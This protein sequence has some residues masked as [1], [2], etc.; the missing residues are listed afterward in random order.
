MPR[1]QRDNRPIAPTP[2]PPA[3]KRQRVHALDWLRVLAFGL[4]IFFHSAVLFIPDAIPDMPN[5]E[6]S[7][8]LRLFV[9]FLHQFRLDL[10]FLVSGVGVCFA[11][12]ARSPRAFLAERSR[13]LL[14]PLVFGILVVV[15]PMVFLEKSYNNALEDGPGGFVAFYGSMFD[16]RVYPDGSLSWHHYWFIDYLYLFCLLALPLFLH[17]RGGVGAGRFERWADWAAQGYRL[18]ALCLPLLAIELALRPLFPGFRNLLGDWASFSHWLTIFIAGWAMAHR[19]ILLDRARTLRRSSLIVAGC[20]NILLFAL[21]Y[22]AKEG[23]SHP[24]ELTLANALSFALFSSL[25]VLSAW[26]WLLC[27]L[28]FALQWLNRP[29]KALGY[30]NRAVYPLFCLHQT[31]IVALGYCILPL[32]WSIGAKFWAISLG[33]FAIVLTLYEIAI[34]RSAVLGAVL[35][36]AREPKKARAVASFPKQRDSERASRR[37]PAT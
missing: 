6:S 7:P 31:T 13:R 18:F 11:L 26:A 10:L 24:Q 9:A 17:W 30:L 34:R 5:A 25:R 4:L 3:G 27:C 22:S 12:G 15:P 29:G 8:A 37:T 23:L 2:P 1:P 21:Y 32:D 36:A 28:G 14:I 35:G 20:A 19:P 16:G 33:T